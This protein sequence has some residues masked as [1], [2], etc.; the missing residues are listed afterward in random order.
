MTK[1]R[2]LSVPVVFFCVLLC[3]CQRLSVVYFA[4]I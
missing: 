1:N 3:D 4:E 2:H